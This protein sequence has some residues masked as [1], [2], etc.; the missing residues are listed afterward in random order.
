MTRK[1]AAETARQAREAFK[2]WERK[3]GLTTGP[4]WAAKRAK[5]HAEGGGSRK[6]AK[7]R[8]GANTASGG[9]SRPP[10][11]KESL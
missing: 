10:G 9:A 2:E 5:A 11:G 7:T 6:T 1:E 4:A 3:R 8:L